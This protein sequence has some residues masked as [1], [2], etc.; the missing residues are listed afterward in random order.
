[1]KKQLF[2]IALILA[3]FTGYSQEIEDEMLTSQDSTVTDSICHHRINI[4]LGGAMTNNIYKRSPDIHQYYSLGSI[5]DIG[6]TYFFNEHW[7]LGI[8]VGLQRNYA[9]AKLNINGVVADAADLA[10]YNQNSIHETNYDLIYNTQNLVEK[11]AIW[12]IEVPL[13]AQFE[14]RFNEKMGLYAGL[15]V[16]GYFPIYNKSKLVD[17]TLIITGY[18]PHN[19]ITYPVAVVN[20]GFGEYQIEGNGSTK[21]RCSFDLQADFGGIFAINNKVDFYVGLYCTY[22]FLDIL[23]KAEN[24]HSFVQ[25]SDNVDKLQ[26]NGLLGSDYLVQYDRK[27]VENSTENIGNLKWNNLQVGVKVGIHIKPCMQVDKTL[28][29]RY[30]EKMIE[31]ADKFIENADKEGEDG[32]TEYVYIVPICPDNMYGDDEG[33]DEGNERKMTRKEKANIKDL[34]KALSKV[35]ILFD[36]DKDIPKIT[37]SNNNIDKAVDILKSDPTLKV[38]VEG[39]TCDLGSEEHNR[40]L[41]RRRAESIKRLFIEKGV[42]IEQIE[43]ASYTYNDDENRKNI[44]ESNREEHRA[45]IF[46]IVKM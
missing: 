30:Y 16:K 19:N 46:R 43:T 42:P 12:A 4:H 15:G 34:A 20:H 1:M 2:L 23:P 5:L 40:D 45:A 18:D 3:V 29:K 14:H 39:Y 10:D 7:G 31:A 38:I 44:P 32:K 6:Y 35:K 26:Y 8:G 17:G 11:Q 37:E 27:A 21:L 22:G 33:D 41:A 28:K 24:Q 13:T 25:L 36:L 9:K